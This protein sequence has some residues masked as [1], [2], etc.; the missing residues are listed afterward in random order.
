[1]ANI[2]SPFLPPSPLLLVGERNGE[3]NGSFAATVYDDI[4]SPAPRSPPTCCGPLV[5]QQFV[6]PVRGN[7]WQDT[8]F[9]LRFVQPSRVASPSYRY[10]SL[11]QNLYYRLN[12]MDNGISRPFLTRVAARPS[13]I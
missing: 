6:P 12:L 13:N 5:C 9:R 10:L 1:M 8:P 4:R 3:R 11:E 7:S 2:A